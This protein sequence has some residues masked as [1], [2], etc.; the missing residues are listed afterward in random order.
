VAAEY[1]TDQALAELGIDH[2][3]TMAAWAAESSLRTEDWA[4]RKTTPAGA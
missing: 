3:Y 1:E 2:P 4:W